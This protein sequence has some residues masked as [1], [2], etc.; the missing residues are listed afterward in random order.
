MR[1]STSMKR[2]CSPT[3]YREFEPLITLR[4]AED[5]GLLG[6]YVL[7]SPPRPKKLSHV[8]MLLRTTSLIMIFLLI[9]C[10]ESHPGEFYKYFFYSSRAV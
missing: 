8:E 5:T 3:G 1:S 4:E 2:S 6:F 9:G 7:Y 10:V